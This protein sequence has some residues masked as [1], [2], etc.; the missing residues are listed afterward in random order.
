MKKDVFWFVTLSLFFL[1]GKSFASIPITLQA[2]P[3]T[4]CIGCSISFSVNSNCS[5][6]GATYYWNFGDGT[7]DTT[8]DPFT[9]HSYSTPGTF[10][11]NALVVTSSDS[12][13]A[14]TSVNIYK[15]GSF[16]INAIKVYDI[17]EHRSWF[18]I[19]AYQIELKDSNGNNWNQSSECM[20]VEYEWWNC[21]DRQVFPSGSS[22]YYTF[23]TIFT[24]SILDTD[25]C[26]VVGFVE[27]KNGISMSESNHVLFWYIKKVEL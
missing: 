10:T 14:S 12:G 4:A 15:L 21:I 2:S 7:G 27:C 18:H 13:S 6:C 26:M 24:T 20:R 8:S 1:C 9:S 17:P 22:S 25:T 23:N 11:V 5:L 3:S 16:K 19:H